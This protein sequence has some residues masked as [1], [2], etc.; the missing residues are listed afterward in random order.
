MKFTQVPEEAL[1][2]MAA[3]R[4]AVRDFMNDFGDSVPAL[5]DM[6]RVV[7][8]RAKQLRS[9]DRTFDLDLAFLEVV[10]DL[11]RKKIH[12]DVLNS[13]PTEQDARTLKQAFLTRP[14]E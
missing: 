2:N 8:S 14:S 7:T 6:Q 1:T 3:A 13:L 9:L 11:I 5:K 4:D 12:E 10:G